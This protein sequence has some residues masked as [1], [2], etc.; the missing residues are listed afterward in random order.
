MEKAESQIDCSERE[1]TE[2]EIA[3]FVEEIVHEVR[4]EKR[5]RELKEFNEAFD[6][7]QAWA[8]SVSLTE[9]DVTDTIKAVRQRKRQARRQIA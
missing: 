7:A 4:R 8:K 9:Q 3:Q 1:L 5:E 6:E 2:E